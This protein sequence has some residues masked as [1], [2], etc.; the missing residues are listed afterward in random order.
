MSWDSESAKWVKPMV[1]SIGGIENTG[2]GWEVRPTVGNKKLGSVVEAWRFNEQVYKS[3]ASGKLKMPKRGR[4]NAG[5]VIAGGI[6][7][8]GYAAEVFLDFAKVQI[9]AEMKR[10]GIQQGRYDHWAKFKEDQGH[11]LELGQAAQY[12]LAPLPQ[13]LKSSVLKRTKTKVRGLPRRRVHG[14][15]RRHGNTVEPPAF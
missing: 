15:S 9:D 10:V 13:R 4:G 1:A 3:W 6:V 2:G 8:F 12:A 11:A 5:N 14:Y 7:A